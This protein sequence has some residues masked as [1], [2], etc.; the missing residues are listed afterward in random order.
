MKFDSK[1]FR[2]SCCAAFLAVSTMACSAPGSNPSESASPKDAQ[3]VQLDPTIKATPV[4]MNVEEKKVGEG[5]PLEGADAFLGEV[6]IWKDKFDGA[7]FGRGGKVEFLLVPDINQMPGLVKATEGMKVGGVKDITIS[8]KELFGEIPPQA[9]LNP[10]TTL[11][12]RFEAKDV[13]PKE[14]L[15]I[16]TVKEGAGDKAAADGDILQV[17]YVGRLDNHK[18]GKVFDS[19]RERGTPFP[20]RL[21]K[22]EV[23]PGWDKGLVGIKKGEVRRLSIPHYLAYGINEKD[24]IPAKSRLFF[25]VELVDFVS[26][27]EL[28]SETVKEGKGEAIA[29]GKP[30]SFHYTGW[31]DGF[32]GKK[33]FDSSKDRNQPFDVALGQGRV[34]KGW[35]TGLVGMKPGEVRRLT[36]PWNLAYGA[37]GSPPTIPPFATLY[38]EVE[39]LGPVKPK[40]TPTPKQTPAGKK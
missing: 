16:E 2:L 24:K 20:V 13:F 39:Y 12:L 18:D 17:H 30:G 29:A 36:I 25:E 5:A 7:P 9:R 22:G 1:L 37:K 15:K 10:A 14:E 6:Q 28:K 35:D 19:S 40:G 21:G 38:F 32:D 31:L 4:A 33:K 23:I 8:A 27:G 11:Y 3:T 34:I 26:E